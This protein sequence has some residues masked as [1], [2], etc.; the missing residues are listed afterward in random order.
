MI[1]PSLAIA[2]ASNILDRHAPSELQRVLGP[3]LGEASPRISEANVDLPQDPAVA[4]LKA[5]QRGSVATMTVAFKP[6]DDALN[7]RWLAPRRI[8]LLPPQEAQQIDFPIG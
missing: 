4:A 6:I 8:T 2:S 3:L 7:S 5:G 1:S